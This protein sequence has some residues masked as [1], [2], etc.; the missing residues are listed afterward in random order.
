MESANTMTNTI[1]MMMT[2]MTKTIKM[3]IIP[4]MTRMM[5]VIHMQQSSTMHETRRSPKK[6][7]I[8][9]PAMEPAV[10]LE[11]EGTT[12]EPEE[13]GHDTMDLEKQSEQV[14]R[15]ADELRLYV[16]SAVETRMEDGGTNNTD[17]PKFSVAGNARAG[18]S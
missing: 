16:G 11:S 2:M 14:R 15:K 4:R 6:E 17:E 12:E 18:G 3:I 8:E 5:I 13:E 7:P 10:K 9:I 1:K